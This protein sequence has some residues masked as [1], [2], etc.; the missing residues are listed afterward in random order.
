[1]GKPEKNGG[2]RMHSKYKPDSNYPLVNVYISV[3]N[4]D[5]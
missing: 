5:V 1:M 2:L 4:Y 3:G